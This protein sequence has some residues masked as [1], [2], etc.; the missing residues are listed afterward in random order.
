MVSG[1]APLQTITETNEFSEKL[2]SDLHGYSA[3]LAKLWP[4]ISKD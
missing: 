4:F 1:A 3:H 2:C